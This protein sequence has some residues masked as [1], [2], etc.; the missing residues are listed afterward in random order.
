MASAAGHTETV[1]A[2]VEGNA[3]LNLRRKVCDGLPWS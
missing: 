2:L 3:E 1:S